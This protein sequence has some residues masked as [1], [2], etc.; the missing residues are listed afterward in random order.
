MH[1]KIEWFNVADTSKVI[2]AAIRYKLSNLV[3]IPI[4]LKPLSA[5]IQ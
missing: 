3:K 4:W 2:A 1:N 5:A